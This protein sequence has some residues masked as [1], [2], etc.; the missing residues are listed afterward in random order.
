[1]ALS[2]DVLREHRNPLYRDN[3]EVL[4]GQTIYKGSLVMIITDV[5]YL[6]V[7]AD[8]AKGWFAGMSHEQYD[9]SGGSSGDEVADVQT[10]GWIRVTLTGV[11]VTDVGKICYVNDDDSVTLASTNH[12]IVGAVKG[13][14]AANEAWVD[15]SARYRGGEP[16]AHIADTAAASAVTATLGAMTIGNPSKTAA[17]P[18]GLTAVAIGDTVS[19]QNTGWGATAEADAD[20]IHVNID[21]L[22][23]DMLEVHTQLIAA[24]VDVD[25]NNSEIDAAKVDIDVIKTSLDLVIVDL[26]AIVVNLGLLNATQDAILVAIEEGK[27]VLTA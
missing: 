16:I 18:A 22:V 20:A 11:A 4:G 1:M 9:N 13:V 27:L 10:D 5:G 2:K 26:T 23:A 24:I 7:A 19:V 17:N 14:A 25:D 21:A 8:T 12:V 6:Q 3:I 15:I